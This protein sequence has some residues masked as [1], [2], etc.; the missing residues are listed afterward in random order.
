MNVGTLLDREQSRQTLER[1]VR[2]QSQ[3]VIES[4]ALGRQG[5]NGFFVSGDGKALLIELTGQPP[6]NPQTVVG[7]ACDVQFYCGK[8]YRFSSTIVAFPQWGESRAVAVARPEIVSVSERRRLLRA[9]LAPSST[10]DLEWTAAGLTQ[11]CTAILLNVSAGGLACRVSAA[12]AQGLS[13]DHTVR[14]AFQLPWQSRLFTVDSAV[15][16]KTPA[17]EG[18]VIL[19]IAFVP[20]PAQEAD[21]RALKESLETPSEVMSVADASH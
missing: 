4:A 1:A 20:T 6:V 5:V 2:G 10:V 3:A 7:Q 8:R 13:S 12:A 18:N 17:S 15:T 11:R 19:G 14:T 21:C 9:T 16:N